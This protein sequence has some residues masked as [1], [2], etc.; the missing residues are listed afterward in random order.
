MDFIVTDPDPLLDAFFDKFSSLWSRPNQAAGFRAYVLGLLS[1]AHRKNVEAMSAKTV[2]EPYQ[3]LHHFLAEAPWDADALNRLRLGLLQADPRTAP[4]PDG[5][6]IVDDTGVPKKGDATEGVKRQYIG[7]VGK[8]ANGQ[9]FVTTHYADPRTHWPVE[10]APYVPDTWLPGGKVDPDFHTKIELALDLVERAVALGIP[11]R[12]VVA[13]SWYGRNMGFIKTLEERDRP[14]VVELQPSQRVFVR[15]AGDLGR[16]EHRLAEA[17]S[18]LKPE[19]FRPVGL[20]AADGTEREVHVARLELKIKRLSGK[21]RVVVVTTQPDDPAAD[22]DLR[23]LLSNVVEL[24]DATVAQLYARRNWVEVFYREAKDDLGA[25][26]YQ[27]R[28]LASIVRHWILVFVAY[29]LL[30]RLKR[31]GRLGRWCKKNSTPSARP[32]GPSATTSGNCS[33]SS[34]CPST[35]NLSKSIYNLKGSSLNP[36]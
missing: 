29:T 16:N 1:E 33:C 30:V 17:L 5:L 34:G 2:G 18:L 35:A 32:S 24:R 25:G 26:Q 14:Y 15:L 20:K 36:S 31:E 13:D 11:F 7:Q 28:D 8:T 19:D 12:A 3:S 10:L 4:R 27:V 23:F 9:V 22:E 21:R 6:L